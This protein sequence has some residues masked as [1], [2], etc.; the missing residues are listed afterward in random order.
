M[1][2]NLKGVLHSNQK[3]TCF[4]LYLKIINTFSKMMYASYSKLSMKLK[5]SIK[6][7]GRPSG[8]W[9]I[10]HNN[11]LTVLIHKLKNTWPTKMS[12]P[13]LS[14]VT[15]CFK[16]HILFLKK[17]LIFLRLNTK[18]VN[19]WL[20][21]QYPLK[22]NHHAF[23]VSR[24]CEHT[25]ENMQGWGW[26]RAIRG[27]NWQICGPRISYHTRLEIQGPNFKIGNFW[28]FAEK[29]PQDTLL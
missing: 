18:N 13:F 11:I 24:E 2:N 6:N 28:K 15:I 12:M 8:S 19:F 22:W 20:E 29:L 23:P 4:V 14:S 1:K 25:G 27:P 9:V 10:D 26:L 16:M 21:V 7:L 17:V 5:N 3:L